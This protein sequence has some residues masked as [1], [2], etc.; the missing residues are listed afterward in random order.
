M[1]FSIQKCV[2]NLILFIAL[3]LVVFFVK[4]HDEESENSVDES[5]SEIKDFSLQLN[6]DLAENERYDNQHYIENNK[7][8]KSFAKKKYIKSKQFMCRNT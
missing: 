4:I 7:L 8:V 2:K 5:S 6:E 3:L 1:K